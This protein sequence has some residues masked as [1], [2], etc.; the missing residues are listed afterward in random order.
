MGRLRVAFLAA[1]SAIAS[2]LISQIHGSV[3]I[4]VGATV[5]G[6]LAGLAAGAAVSKKRKNGSIAAKP[7]AAQFSDGL[8]CGHSE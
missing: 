6:V 2:V 4:D 1:L 8:H 5:V 7:I 3:P